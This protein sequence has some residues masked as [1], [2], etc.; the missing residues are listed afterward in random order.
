MHYW[1]QRLQVKRW[2]HRQTSTS[3]DGTGNTSTDGER[4]G[5]RPACKTASDWF[6]MVCLYQLKLVPTGLDRVYTQ[7]SHGVRMV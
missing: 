5:P 2:Q 3:P 1:L 7:C 4:R 6:R